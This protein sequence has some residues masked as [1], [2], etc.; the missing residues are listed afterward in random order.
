MRDSR[1]VPLAREQRRGETH[2]RVL[3][4]DRGKRASERA[5]MQGCLGAVPFPRA[6]LCAYSS[7]SLPH[8]PSNC[9]ESSSLRA[10]Y[11]I[12]PVLP[13]ML[14]LLPCSSSSSLPC[15]LRV[16]RSFRICWIAHPFFFSF[17]SRFLKSPGRNRPGGLWRRPDEKTC[18]FSVR[19]TRES[20]N[21]RNAKACNKGI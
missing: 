2:T 19:G 10:R 6:T 20:M 5:F 9:P 15:L 3:S 13:D 18:G 14:P 21:G 4:V 1:G 17:F 12:P 8:P 11:E 7:F 16:V